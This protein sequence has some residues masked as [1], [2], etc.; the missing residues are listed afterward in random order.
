[1]SS[2]ENNITYK[3]FNQ[4]VVYSAGAAATPTASQQRGKTPPIS[5]L[6]YDTKQLNGEALEMVELREM[7]PGPLWPEVVG[8]YL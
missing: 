2:F 6:I 8:S 4:Y 3:L 7:L 5:I 1:M